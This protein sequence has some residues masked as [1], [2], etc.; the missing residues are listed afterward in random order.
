MVHSEVGGVVNTEPD[1]ARDPPGEAQEG[2]GEEATCA[3]AHVFRCA[4][5]QEVALLG[6]R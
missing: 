3:A 2:E 5:P 1:D 6:W 4:P